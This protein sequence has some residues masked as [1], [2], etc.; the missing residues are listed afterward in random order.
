MLTKGS[1]KQDSVKVDPI[2]LRTIEVQLNAYYPTTG[3]T[4]DDFTV[5]IVPE[6]LELTYLGAAIGIYGVVLAIYESGS[7]RKSNPITT[8][9]PKKDET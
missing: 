3:V 4:T 1:K 6:E 9:E 5:T 7:K 8:D 2:A